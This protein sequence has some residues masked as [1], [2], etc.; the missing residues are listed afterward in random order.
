VAGI[1]CVC[2]VLYATVVDMI[3]NDAFLVF[4][5]LSVCFLMVEAGCFLV[6]HM[7][8]TWNHYHIL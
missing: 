1:F 2:C 6:L 7:L 4:V 3:S 8:F 5:N